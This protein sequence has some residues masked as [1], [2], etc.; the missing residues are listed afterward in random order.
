MITPQKAPPAPKLKTLSLHNFLQGRR[1]DTDPTRTDN[2]ALAVTDNVILE[3]D[4]V[5]RVR[6]STVPYGAQPLGPV[7]GIDEFVRIVSGVPE[8]WLITV[9]WVG[10]AGKV[11]VNKDGGA[12][13]LCTGATYQNFPTT[14]IQGAGKVLILNGEDYLSYLD[15]T[16]LTVT[17]F[18]FLAAP[19]APT[20]TP[21]GMTGSAVTYRYR[22]SAVS[23]V[24]ETNASVA[25]TISTS[26]TRDQW[27]QGGTTPRYMT[28]SWSAIPL[29]K[30]YAI[31]EGTEAGKERFLGVVPSTQLSYIDDGSAFEI[32]TKLAPAGNGT[33]GPVVKRGTNSA[34][35]IFMVGDKTNPYHVWY[36]GANEDSL[37]FS[38][39]NG[40]GW[41]DIAVGSKNIPIAVVPFRDGKGTPMAT[42]FSNG[43][44]GNG[45]ITHLSLQTLNVG[46][47][48]ITYMQADEANGQDGTGSPDAI[49]PYRDSLWYPSGATFKTTGAKPNVPNVLSTNNIDDAII[50]DAKKLNRASMYGASGVGYNGC[51]YWALPVGGSTNNQIW[52]LDLIR[53]G[54][55]MLPLSIPAKKLLLYGSTDGETHFLA[56]VGDRLLEFTR[57]RAAEDDG[58]TFSSKVGTGYIKA[59]KSGANWMYIVDVTFT[60]INPQGNINLAVQGKT[61]Q[62]SISNVGSKQFTPKVSYAGWG[63]IKYGANSRTG[64]VNWGEVINVPSTYGASRV[65]R[66]IPVKKLV[67]YL[68]AEVSGNGNHDY[69]VSDIVIRYVDVGM[70]VTQEMRL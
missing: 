63:E 23:S 56:L 33:Q 12:W 3:Q 6:P 7:L 41:I 24:G 16:T 17:P 19:A 53:G 20:V 66:T 11:Y 29:A 32:V 61:K 26:Q 49:I 31:Y 44:N 69:A 60:L 36:G 40:G 43:T 67:N 37:D 50:E 9:Q 52:V 22:I 65:V 59:D 62:A 57:S 47:S 51:L 68:Q 46:D 38:P 30:G 10:G 58:V 70:I 13:Q 34:G 25:T 4:G 27:S 64:D 28:L 15:T 54:K 14:F 39:Y 2:D 18:A 8:T 5:V 1:S 48:V 35:Q 21:T 55:W 45:K 42:V